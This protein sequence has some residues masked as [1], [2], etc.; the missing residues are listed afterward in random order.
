MDFVRASVSRRTD[1][2]QDVSGKGIE[3]ETQGRRESLQ[4]EP[5][6]GL[7]EGTGFPQLVQGKRGENWGESRIPCNILELQGL[8]PVNPECGGTSS[9]V[10]A[11]KCDFCTIAF[12]AGKVSNGTG[13]RDSDGP[14]GQG[15]ASKQVGKKR[16]KRNRAQPSV[17][18]RQGT[19]DR[20]R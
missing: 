7:Y 2:R 11:A 1:I 12:G 15:A 10:W 14:A 8:E 20:E 19:G 16:R 13:K 17:L 6:N 4:R 18:N 5:R 3:H 9:Q